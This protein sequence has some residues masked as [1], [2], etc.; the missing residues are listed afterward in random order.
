MLPGDKEPPL[1]GNV[2]LAVEDI[3]LVQDV[4]ASEAEGVIPAFFLH[5]GVQ[6]E[7]IVILVDGAVENPVGEPLSFDLTGPR[8]LRPVQ[9]ADELQPRK[10]RTDPVP[11]G[12]SFF[13]IRPRNPL[14]EAP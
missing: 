9:P 10:A 7:N 13:G 5:R 1:G 4:G 11:S 2:P 12:G 14:G 3:F 6:E 8:P